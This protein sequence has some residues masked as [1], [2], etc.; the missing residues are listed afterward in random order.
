MILN[1]A[2]KEITVIIIKEFII[3]GLIV[4][5]KFTVEKG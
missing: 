5:A 2:T 1:E 3:K 4:I